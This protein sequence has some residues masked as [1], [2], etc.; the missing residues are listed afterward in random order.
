MDY[1]GLI[2]CYTKIKEEALAGRVPHGLKERHLW[3]EYHM[4]LN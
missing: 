2:L 4:G 3:E 1:E